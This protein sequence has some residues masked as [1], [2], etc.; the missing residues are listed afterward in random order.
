METHADSD[1]FLRGSSYRNTLQ[2]VTGDATSPSSIP[3]FSPVKQEPPAAAL[4]SHSST[5]TTS[6][7]TDFCCLNPDMGGN[8]FDRRVSAT[9]KN[10]I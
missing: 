2:A 3:R 9:L 7:S 5:G 1:G 8:Q 4:C 6:S 10:S